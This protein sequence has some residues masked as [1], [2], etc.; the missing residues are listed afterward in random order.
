MV[1]LA[2]VAPREHGANQQDPVL[3]APGV[4]RIGGDEQVQGLADRQSDQIC[5]VF[6]GDSRQ[7]PIVLLRLM[8]DFLK[9]DGHS[10][11]T[12]DHRNDESQV[13]LFRS[14]CTKSVRS[15]GTKAGIKRSANRG[16]APATAASNIQHHHAAMTRAARRVQIRPV[17]SRITVETS[18][19][20]YWPF[21]AK[22]SMTS[23]PESGTGSFPRHS[24]KGGLVYS[25]RKRCGA[26]RS[27]LGK[28][29][30]GLRHGARASMVARRVLTTV[31][32]GGVFPACGA[33]SG[34]NQRVGSHIV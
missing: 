21:E 11:R 26:G 33:V 13:K 24:H 34:T 25:R 9:P 10:R 18:L 23:F 31:S 22:V 8:R 27:R 28:R 1:E 3:F 17:E 7:V 32:R 5:P 2:A 19:S 6:R 16:C 15:S 4:A 29:R 14:G 12:S 30:A 20:S